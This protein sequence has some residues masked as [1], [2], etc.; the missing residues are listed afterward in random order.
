MKSNSLTASPLLSRFDRALMVCAVGL[1]S[2]VAAM[3]APVEYSLDDTGARVAAGSGVFTL[4]VG[5]VLTDYK[6]T[7]VSGAGTTFGTWHAVSFESFLGTFPSLVISNLIGAKVVYTMPAIGGSDIQPGSSADLEWA[8]FIA[9]AGGA[10]GLRILPVGSP[11]PEG[12][13]TLKLLALGMGAIGAGVLRKPRKRGV[14]ECRLHG[15]PSGSCMPE[16]QSSVAHP[17]QF[18]WLSTSLPPGS[19]SS[20]AR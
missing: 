13:S 9:E 19:G 7:A 18:R 1:V 3:A 11:V 14:H 5:P 10:F 2:A 8:H 16:D 6:A 12:T 20:P 15:L 4:D 17:A